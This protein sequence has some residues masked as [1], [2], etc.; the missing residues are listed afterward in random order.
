[1]GQDYTEE[2]ETRLAQDILLL[3]IESRLEREAIERNK[4]HGPANRWTGAALLLYSPFF[5]S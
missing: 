5:E 3:D 4:A 2:I 1:M